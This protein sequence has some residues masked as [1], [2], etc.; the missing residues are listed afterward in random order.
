[1]L[2]AATGIYAL[3]SYSVTQRTHE[4][5][6]RVVLGGRPGEVLRMMV[7]HG[8]KLVFIGVAMGL[9]GAFALTRVMSGLL[10][11]VSATDPTALA[12]VSLLLIGVALGAYFVPARRA[13]RVDPMIAL[14][15]E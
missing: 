8:M 9:A 3:I 4:I 11:E 13:T 10:Y 5:G 15:Y 2:L 12:I 1:L 7:W 14:R 6:I